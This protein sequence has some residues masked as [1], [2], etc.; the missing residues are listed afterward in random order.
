LKKLNLVDDVVPETLGGA[1]R[2]PHGTAKN[3]EAYLIRTI[4][5]L[6]RYKPENLVENRYKRLRG[7]GVYQ[8]AEPKVIK[9]VMGVSEKIAELPAE[10]GSKRNAVKQ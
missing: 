5:E 3:L 9:N 7:I 8:I 4:R 1:H 2:N 6:K 10:A